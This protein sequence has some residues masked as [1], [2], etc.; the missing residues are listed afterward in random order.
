[1]IFGC[2]LIETVAEHLI[3]I[4][5][6]IRSKVCSSKNLSLKSETVPIQ[7]KPV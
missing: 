7:E 1:M 5:I 2:F 6:I 3:V 4:D